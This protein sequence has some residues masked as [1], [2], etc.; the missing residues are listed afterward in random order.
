MSR[1]DPLRST[2]SLSNVS[3]VQC[4]QS[5]NCSTA[6]LVAFT[7]LWTAGSSCKTRVLLS[8]CPLLQNFEHHNQIGLRQSL[9]KRRKSLIHKNETCVFPPCLH[10][11]STQLKRQVRQTAQPERVCWMAK[12]EYT[13]S[14]PL[15]CT[16]NTPT[17]V[18]DGK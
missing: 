6:S 11:S 15:F 7:R 5:P 2:N 17:T 4:L 14:V 12:L 18:S 9:T 1:E 16:L 8:S 13:S 10:Y 3:P